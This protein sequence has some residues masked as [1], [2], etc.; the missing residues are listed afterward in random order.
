MIRVLNDY[1][2]D[3]IDL[4]WQFPPNKVKKDR[5]TFSAIWHKFKKVAGYGK[6]KDEHEQEHRDGF[7]IMVRDLKNQLR[8]K[9]K[10]LTLTVLPHINASSESLR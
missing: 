1:D 9:N 8:N 4:A 2:F 10:V 5:G 6:F 7:T 3:G